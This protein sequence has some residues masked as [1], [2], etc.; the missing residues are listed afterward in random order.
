MNEILIILRTLI[1]D[2]SGSTYSDDSLNKLIV[3]A[4]LLVQ[5]ELYFENSYVIDISNTL[6]APDSTDNIF[7]LFVAHKSAILLISSEIRSFSRSSI[8]FSDGLSTLDKTN[9]TKDLS[10]L[11]DYLTTQYELMKRDYTLSQNEGA[12]FGYCVTTPTTVS[13]ISPNTF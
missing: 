2:I 12:S 9:V 6:I 13:Y 10:S 7:N 4:A 11:L 3:V 1:N 5:K 8:K